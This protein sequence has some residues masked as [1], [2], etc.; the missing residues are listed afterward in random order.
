MANKRRVYEAPSAKG[1]KD[2]EKCKRDTHTAH[3][4]Q[5]RSVGGGVGGVAEVGK[6]V[7]VVFTFHSRRDLAA[8]P[9]DSGLANSKK[10]TAGNCTRR[11]YCCCWPLDQT[12]L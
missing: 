5:T 6:V 3:T 10:D 7:K 9:T 11:C 12:R 4:G 2:N 8:T 1:R